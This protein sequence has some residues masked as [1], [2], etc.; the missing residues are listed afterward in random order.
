[1]VGLL[2]A[3]GSEGVVPAKEQP[4]NSWVAR[5]RMVCRVFGFQQFW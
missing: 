1:M 4:G 2:D 5:P 3:T